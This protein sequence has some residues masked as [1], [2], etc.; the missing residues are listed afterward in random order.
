M[1][2][3]KIVFDPYSI[4][5]TTIVHLFVYKNDI[6][7]LSETIG[8]NANTMDFTVSPAQTNITTSTDIFS[9]YGGWEIKLG[10]SPQ[11][12]SAAATNN[13]KLVFYDQLTGQPVQSDVNYDLKILDANGGIIMSKSNLVAKGGTDVQSINM[14]SNGIYVIKVSVTS[15]LNND[16]LDTSRPGT[17]RGN[18][19]VPEFGAIVTWVMAVALISIIVISARSGLRFSLK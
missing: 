1:N 17:A 15:F 8:T 4:Q 14:P 11:I 7:K 19:V 9:D 18:V 10:W 13:L 2:P 5:N 12:L 6:Q 16:I 3:S